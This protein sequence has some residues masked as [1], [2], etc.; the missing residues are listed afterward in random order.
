VI[1]SPE[2]VKILNPLA[3]ELEKVLVGAPQ[4]YQPQLSILSLK[5]MSL[6]ERKNYLDFIDYDYFSFGEE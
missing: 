2:K 3:I 6:Y 1:G 5:D 4:F